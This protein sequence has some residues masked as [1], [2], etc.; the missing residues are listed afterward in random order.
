MSLQPDHKALIFIASIAVL[1]AGVRVVRAAG[2]DE[3]PAVQPALER[4]ALAADSSKRAGRGGKGRAKQKAS[5]VPDTAHK[6]PATTGD[7]PGHIRGRLDLDVATAAQV[8]S[9]PGVTPEMARRIVSDRVH[10]GPF[11]TRDG[12]RRVSGVGPAF[13]AR[14]DSLVTFS[15]TYPFPEASDTV[16][17]RPAKAR[18]KKATRPAVLRT[19]EPRRAPWLRAAAD[20]SRPSRG[21]AVWRRRVT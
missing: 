18:P 6:A 21:R 11:L 19:A 5:H 4:Q 13:L 15:G 20:S 17:P 14:I 7:G 12:L 3:A 9:L 10:H 2:R 8:D 16:I 1:G